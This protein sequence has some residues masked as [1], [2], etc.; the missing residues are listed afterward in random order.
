VAKCQL[1]WNQAED[2][3][4]VDLPPRMKGMLES[5]MREVITNAL[6]HASPNSIQVAVEASSTGLKM[7][8][9][10]DGDIADPFTWQDGYGLRNIRGRMEELGGNLHIS[11]SEDKVRLTLAVPLP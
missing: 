4:E 5:V 7:D 2:V 6:K 10:N 1:H 3:P 9:E 8:V 11:S